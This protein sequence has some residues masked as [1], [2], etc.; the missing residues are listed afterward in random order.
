ML[1]DHLSKSLKNCGGGGGGGG[2]GGDGG[3][4]GV[5]IDG[6]TPLHHVKNFFGRLRKTMK[7]P[8]VKV[9]SIL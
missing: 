5:Y 4:G 2:G 6:I 3:I 7:F 9:V 1:C 8:T